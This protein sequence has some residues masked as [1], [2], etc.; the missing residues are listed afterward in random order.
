MNGTMHRD[1]VEAMRQWEN[2]PCGGL[3]SFNPDS[4]ADWERLDAERY[5]IYAPWMCDTLRF[6][7]YAGKRVLEIGFGQG[8][9]LMQFARSGSEVYGIDLTARHVELTSRRFRAFGMR[10]HLVRGDAESLPFK[11]EFFDL[12]YSFGVLH[13]TPDMEAAV[14][15]VHRVLARG[16]IFVLAVYHRYSLFIAWKIAVEGIL[17]RQLLGSG[18]RVFLSRIEHRKKPDSALPLVK[19]YSRGQLRR[20]LKSF[21]HTT[22]LIRHAGLLFSPPAEGDGKIKAAIKRSYFAN[23]EALSRRFGWYLVAVAE[24]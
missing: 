5:H 3:D 17:H 21:R 8:T 10:A 12:V 20:L 19:L 2:D 6:Q 13:H 16:G 14:R 18:W 4:R 1:K 22:F 15:E 24:K 9:D 7:R 23:Q 11:N